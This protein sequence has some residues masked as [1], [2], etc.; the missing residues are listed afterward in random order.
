MLDGA[1]HGPSLLTLFDSW[2]RALLTNS[3]LA[4]AL[5][6]IMKS[7]I[8]PLR[9]HRSKV[10]HLSSADGPRVGTLV[11]MKMP[12]LEKYTVRGNAYF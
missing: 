1:L 2:G 3:P 12:T 5:K 8:N 6:I 11:C 10:S 4:L 9:D 7:Q